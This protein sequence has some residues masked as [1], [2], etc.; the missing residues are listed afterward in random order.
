M[1]QFLLSKKLGKDVDFVLTGMGKDG[2]LEMQSIANF[3]GITIAKK[4]S[5]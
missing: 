2:A 1:S 3:G 5:K 4:I